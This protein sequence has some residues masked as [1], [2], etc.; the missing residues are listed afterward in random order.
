MR[1]TSIS[2]PAW[3]HL[4]VERKAAAIMILIIG[5]P[6][7]MPSA[8]IYQKVLARGEQACFFDT[9]RFPGEIQLSFDP[10]AAET[11][12]MALAGYGD[13]AL[14]DVRSVYRRWSRGVTAPQETDPL[15]QET[16]YWNLDS[17]IG[18]F[19]RCLDCLWV[20]SQ[21]AT[22]LHNY[23]GY[24]LKLLNAAGIRTPKTLITNH[25]DAMRTFYEALGRQVIYK[26][27][28]GWAHTEMLTEQDFTP[29]RLAGLARS[30]VKLQEYVPG[31]DIRVYVIQNE[32]FAMEIQSSTLDFR[33]DQE[34]PRVKIELPPA[35]ATDCLKLARTLNLVF[36]GIDLRRTPD[37]E[38]VFFEGN[39]TPVFVYDEQT[40]GYPI[41][42]R[43]T[44]LLIAGQ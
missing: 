30:P 8:V 7:D 34:A 14:S 36:A 12:F 44:D 18:S 35:V 28:R 17:A 2:G 40:S 9:T 22:L 37:G 6:S 27:V 43:L 33:E 20:N 19:F 16:V 1:Y 5:I 38:Y 3:G 11:G 26:P 21:E 42:D 41:S 15:L 23:K 25:S 13:Y 31:T 29:E 24:Q 10:C 4:F 39:P 32:L